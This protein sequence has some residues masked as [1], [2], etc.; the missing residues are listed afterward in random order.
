MSKRKWSSVSGLLDI[1]G[2]AEL[3]NP[4]S[5]N[6]L[7]PGWSRDAIV[8]NYCEQLTRGFELKVFYRIDTYCTEK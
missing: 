2:K 7:L 6:G 4:S 8:Y 1:P 3:L 5:T